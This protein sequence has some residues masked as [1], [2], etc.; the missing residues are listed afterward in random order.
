MH[1]DI[2][3]ITISRRYSR[4]LILNHRV[5]LVSTFELSSGT[6]F[7]CMFS[8]KIQHFQKTRS[9]LP[10]N[11]LSKYDRQK[12][13]FFVMPTTLVFRLSDMSYVIRSLIGPWRIPVVWECNHSCCMNIKECDREVNISS[14]LEARYLFINSR[15]KIFLLK[16]HWTYSDM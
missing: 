6:L 4:I 8:L 7:H 15:S 10:K 2:N 5:K 14:V 9:D 12:L 3:R 16:W 13:I 1:I 11:K